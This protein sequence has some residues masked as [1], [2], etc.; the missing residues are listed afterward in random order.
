MHL[1]QHQESWRETVYTI[2]YPTCHAKPKEPGTHQAKIKGLH[3]KHKHLN[4]LHSRDQSERPYFSCLAPL[5]LPHWDMQRFSSQ[6]GLNGEQLYTVH[7][8][9][10]QVSEVMHCGIFV[11]GVDEGKRIYIRVLSLLWN[12]VLLIKTIL[13]IMSRHEIRF[14]CLTWLG[15]LQILMF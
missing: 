6:S 15:K 14:L 2:L 13:R 10:S 7:V 1:F 5:R 3:L 4:G 9:F 12:L 11:I 8:C